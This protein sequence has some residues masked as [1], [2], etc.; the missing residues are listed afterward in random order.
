MVYFVT[1][2]VQFFATSNRISVTTT[3]T[4]LINYITRKS[5]VSTQGRPAFEATLFGGVPAK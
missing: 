4:A 1:H 3:V 2:L 5:R